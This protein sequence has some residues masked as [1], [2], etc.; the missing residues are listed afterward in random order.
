MKKA[1]IFS[2]VCFIHLL[3]NAQLVETY[4][5]SHRFLYKPFSSYIRYVWTGIGSSWRLGGSW[6]FQ[7]NIHD[8]VFVHQCHQ[9]PEESHTVYGVALPINIDRNDVDAYMEMVIN[10]Y[11][12]TGSMVYLA[13]SRSNEDSL[14]I[15]ESARIR[16]GETALTGNFFKMPDE[17]TLCTR[18]YPQAPFHP[19]IEVYFNTP[20]TLTGTFYVASNCD[21]I[22][23]LGGGELIDRMVN[24]VIDHVMDSPYT[25]EG[26]NFLIKH[27]RYGHYIIDSNEWTGPFPI[28]TPPPCM[29]P[30]KIRVAEQFKHGA[31]IECKVQYGTTECELEY[32]PQG[33]TPGTGTTIGSIYPNSQY[34]CQQ[35]IQGLPMDQDITVR[36]RAN[37]PATSSYSDWT[38]LNFHTDVFYTVATSVNNDNWGYVLGGGDHHA[39]TTIK[40][41]A[42]PKSNLCPF[43]NWSDG[44]NQ[45]PRTV[46]VTRDTS[47]KAIFR[48]DSVGLHNTE[49]ASLEI[50]PNPAINEV[51]VLCS[52]AIES[53]NIDDMLGRTVKAGS[54]NSNNIHIPISTLL[55]GIY[56]LRIR[57]AGGTTT[58]KL[59][60]R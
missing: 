38:E 21:Y 14:I 16:L 18:Y 42:Y 40:L 32:G 20:H 2:L 52:S 4:P 11:D 6:D 25:D 51:S 31:I 17:D 1:F 34:K 12:T 10:H 30:V 41:Y 59:I 57:T 3:A 29:P 56:I 9:Q 39:D 19:V 28:V 33:F 26:N 7:Y 50:T 53:W 5:V 49:P 37:C 46:T 23:G 8:Y 36:I 60:K 44:S 13:T 48:C 24:G 27:Q 22:Y 58:K 45:N 15:L 35:I 54:A 55:P 47:F 43:V